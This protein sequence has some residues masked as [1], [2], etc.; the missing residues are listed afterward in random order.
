MTVDLRRANRFWTSAEDYDLPYE[1]LFFPEAEDFYLQGLEG[2]LG[3]VFDL[4]LLREY[5]RSH[6][7]RL[8]NAKDLKCIMA[9]TL[10]EKVLEEMKK[11]RP[12][13]AKAREIHERRVLRQSQKRWK[14]TFCDDV[15]TTIYAMRAGTVP[16]MT[17]MVVRLCEEMREA[18]FTT[19]KEAI[20]FF[21]DLF[22]RHFHVEASPEK[23]KAIE[24]REEKKP[25]EK[26]G[27]R[28]REFREIVTQTT[29]VEELEKYSIGSA[30]F[31]SVEELLT[32]EEAPILVGGEGPNVEEEKIFQKVITRY[33]KSILSPAES[34]NLES[35]LS[36]GIHEGI[37]IH[38]TRGVFPED[39]SAQYYR[40]N[41]LQGELEARRLWE[42]D[43]LIYRRSVLQ[44]MEILKKNVL[45]ELE[46]D[47]TRATSGNLV[48]SR[49]WRREI[50]GDERLFERRMRTEATQLSVDL[51]LDASGSQSE[52]Q[53]Q[54]AIQGMIIAEALTRL[55]IPTRV[56]GYHNLFHVQV[57]DLYRDYH[58]PREA[59]GRIFR[60]NTSGSNRDG[61]A[62]RLVTETMSREAEERLLIVL[63]DGK[64]NDKIHLG[65]VGGPKLPGT[66]Y[67]EEEAIAD[68]AREVLQARMKGVLVL[69]IFTGE[70]EDLPSQQTIYGRDFA[71]TKEI[72]R[73]AP[74]VGRYLK[75]LVDAR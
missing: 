11:R 74:T 61:F 24:A 71:Y 53:A 18:N 36:T 14:K 75:G 23:K 38:V 19:T 4:D 8:T 56:M 46:E 39:L 32:A 26:R 45:Q 22:S 17:P 29:P 34:H 73:F 21:E 42:R 52:R 28:R 68:T 3:Y 25:G 1:E 27:Q 13:L 54:V 16:K 31:T 30:E 10:E 15:T 64:P 5:M 57:L 35:R 49:M 62:L 51:L 37:R 47:I 9:L 65:M 6:I 48:A 67:E 69:G 72:S 58:E 41:V 44:L 66:N 40:D 20:A 12:G 55:H 43:E 33:G 60:Y 70:A 59:N 7:N 50:L 2:F 63:N